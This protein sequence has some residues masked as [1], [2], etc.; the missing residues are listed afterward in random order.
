M[1]PVQ[2][3]NPDVKPA[4]LIVSGLLGLLTACAHGPQ[5]PAPARFM[6]SEAEFEALFPQRLPF[7]SYAGFREAVQAFPEFAARGGEQRQ[8]QEMAAFFAN[9]AHES[10]SL[11][12]LREYNTANYGLY[13]DAARAPGC[14]PGQQYYGR[15]PIQLSWNFNYAE[16]GRVLG[17][18]LWSDPDRVARDP[19]IAWATALWYWMS[20]SGPGRMTPHQAMVQGAGFGETV[21]SI[22]G[23]IE[24]DKPG[25][26]LVRRKLA[27]RIAFYQTASALFAVPPQSPLA[28]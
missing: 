13:C 20:Q 17:V 14:A 8:R 22:N 11:Q 10:D 7:Y 12:A 1:I 26:E 2:H 15:G 9:L 19:Q 21:R 25:D 27:R 24:C 16:V 3:Q 6:P 4:V 28:C 23:L 18:D 5:P